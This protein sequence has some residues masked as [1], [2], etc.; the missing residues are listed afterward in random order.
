VLR[1]VLTGHVL[2]GH[3]LARP[4]PSRGTRRR[5]D[6][7][8]DEREARREPREMGTRRRS[9]L[10]AAARTS[11]EETPTGCRKEEA[12]GAKLHGQELGA[13]SSRQGRARARRRKNTWRPAH[14]RG[15]QKPGHRG[16]RRNLK[17]SREERHGAWDQARKEQGARRRA[18]APASSN[19][20]QGAVTREE[21]SR[22]GRRK[23]CWSRDQA[24]A[25]RRKWRIGD[26]RAG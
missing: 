23:P 16:A 21:R 7:S 25:V 22:Q 2:S 20:E 5:A 17:P 14:I 12:A 3:L 19:R 15:E 10:R 24:S 9:R 11:V 6:Q 1:V 8:K 18:G 13:N 4:W 26:R